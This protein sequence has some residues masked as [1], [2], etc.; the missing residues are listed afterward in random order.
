MQWR[1][2]LPALALILFAVGTL[3]SLSSKATLDKS[4]SRYFW[5]E[6]V[7]LDPD[8]L[9]RHTPPAGRIS[10]DY[11]SVW[12]HPGLLV[13]IFLVLS[14]PAFVTVGFIV[15]ELGRFGV[16]EILSF[17]IAM[18]PALFAWYYLVGILIDRKRNRQVSLSP[19]GNSRA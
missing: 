10:W 12:V 9:N 4:P 5:W 13:G 18:P 19:P 8:P 2:L 15:S 11:E 14:L 6:S 3:D 7:R 1:F 17:M 16:N